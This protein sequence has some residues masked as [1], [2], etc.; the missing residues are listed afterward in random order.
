MKLNAPTVIAWWIALILAVLGIIGYLL[1]VTK[2]WN[3]S[4]LMH[5]S[6]WIEVLAFAVL[7]VATTM[8]KI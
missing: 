8:K 1:V 3:P 2:A 6:L 7:A 4:W 5:L